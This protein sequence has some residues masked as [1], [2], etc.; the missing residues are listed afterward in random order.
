ML[1]VVCP[2]SAFKSCAGKVIL[3]TA[4]K[5]RPKHGAPRVLTVGVRRFTMDAGAEKLIGVRIRGAAGPFI[6]AKGLETRARI[7]G[8]DGAGPARQSKIRFRLSR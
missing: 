1:R 3:T 2:P 6:G 7:S 8:F 5:V 4:N